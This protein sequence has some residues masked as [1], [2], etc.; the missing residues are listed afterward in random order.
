MHVRTVSDACSGNVIAMGHVLKAPCACELDVPHDG[1]WTAGT[2]VR[3]RSASTWSWLMRRA[4]TQMCVEA[5]VGGFRLHS[6]APKATAATRGFTK[7]TLGKLEA[8]SD[9]FSWSRRLCWRLPAG[10]RLRAMPK[11]VKTRQELFDFSR[12]DEYAV[13]DL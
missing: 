9:L 6:P 4:A 7:Q 10:R 8:G 11:H 13:R 5:I 1:A 3:E 12:F 2:T